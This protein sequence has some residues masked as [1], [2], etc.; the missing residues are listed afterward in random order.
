MIPEA[1]RL[2][3]ATGIVLVALVCAWLTAGVEL[4]VG[5]HGASEMLWPSGKVRMVE[6]DSGSPARPALEALAEEEP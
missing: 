6:K 3:L 1:R 5:A 4:Y 2:I